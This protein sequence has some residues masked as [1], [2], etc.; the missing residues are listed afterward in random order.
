M[1]RN[2]LGSPPQKAT[3]AHTRLVN[4]LFFPARALFMGPQGYL[5]LDSLKDERMSIVAEYSRGRVLD[6]GCGPG[7]R[8]IKEFIGVDHGIGIDFFAYE[9][10]DNVIDDPTQLPFPDATFDTVTLIA[11]GGHIPR[12]KR[13]EEFC[14]FARLLR[15]G[16]RLIM[17]EGEPIT[18]QLVHAWWHFY[19]GLQGKVDIDH[20]RQMAD[21]EELCMP[22]AELMGYIS[23]PPFKFVL[24]RR[25][26]WGLN[27]VYVAERL[28]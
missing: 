28:P 9:G 5:G 19:L 10:V 11:V 14:E 26:M 21:D 2:A 13:N 27:N 17:T 20:Q 15:P 16:G 4:K 18:Q 24:R 25:F 7:N 12:S 22:R 3:T 8:F 6:V 1:M 23:T